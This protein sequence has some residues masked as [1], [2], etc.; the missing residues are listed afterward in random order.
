MRGVDPVTAL[1]SQLV[2]LDEAQRHLLL[3][4]LSDPSRGAALDGAWTALGEAVTIMR[5]EAPDLDVLLDLGRLGQV[6][7]PR[8]LRRLPDLLVLVTGSSAANVVATR[9]AAS[10]LRDESPTRLGLLVV[11]PDRPYTAAEVAEACG[12]D[13]LEVLPHDPAGALAWQ[14]PS[15]SWR[16]K[17]SPVARGLRGLCRSLSEIEP[18]AHTGGAG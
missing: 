7:D 1:W 10:R 14:S 9:A 11:A 17:R 13:L 16:S 2:A 4:G 15:Q 3:L 12:L 5:S 8:G 6:H 18:L